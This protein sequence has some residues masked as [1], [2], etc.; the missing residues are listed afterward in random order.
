[1][2]KSIDRRGFEISEAD[3][4]DEA[5]LAIRSMHFDLYLFA[6]ELAPRTGMDLVREELGHGLRGAVIIV[7]N[8]RD[9]AIDREA[10]DGGACG[11]LVQGDFDRKE[12]D[13]AIRFAIQTHRT[14][15]ELLTHS[16]SGEESLVVS[17]IGTKGGVGVTTLIAN[18]S[19]ALAQSSQRVVTFEMRAYFGT[20][21]EQLGLAPTTDLGHLAREID[22]PLDGVL[23]AEHLTLHDSGARLLVSPQSVA[24]FEAVSAETAVTAINAAT[25]MCDIVLVDLP[26]E[27]SETTREILRRSDL[28]MLVADR[29]GPT[30]GTIELALR[31]LDAWGVRDTT[32][33]VLIDRWQLPTTNSSQV[34]ANRCNVALL[35][36]VG[37]AREHARAAL[38]NCSPFVTSAPDHFTAQEMVRLAD[39]FRE[40][41]LPTLSVHG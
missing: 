36:H 39:T 35:A 1:M 9:D 21:A 32:G 40:R 34:I 23:L 18:L 4:Y 31:Q 19:I 20:L 25:E 26:P 8:E 12:L 15:V 29:E 11:Y 33:L 13:R 6:Y 37:A 3:S 24:G 7:S 30:L 17:A 10:I 28:T 2:V 16:G 41:T 22:R 14:N 5:V 27:P 38:D